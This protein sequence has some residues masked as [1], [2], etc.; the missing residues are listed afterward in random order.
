MVV[1]M[2]AGVRGVGEIQR[3]FDFVRLA[4]P[5]AQDGKSKK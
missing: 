4:P 1:E 3:Y 2:R 5:Y